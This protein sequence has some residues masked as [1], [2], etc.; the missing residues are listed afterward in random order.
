[1]TGIA[2]NTKDS[3]TR[4]SEVRRED[5]EALVN[6]V[7][8]V[9]NRNAEL[10]KRVEEL[11]YDY[12]IKEREK[13]GR[14][15]F[16]Y[17]AFRALKFNHIDGDY[18]EF[19]SHG[20]TTFS[21]AYQES[22]RQSRKTR[23]WAFD[24]FQG[25]PA[26]TETRDEHPGWVEKK[27]TTSLDRF[28]ELCKERGV[29]RDAYTVVPGYYNQT[30]PAMSATDEPNNIA[31]AYIDCD[32]YS[33][34]RDVLDFLK[35]RV[36]HGMILAFDDYFCWSSTQLSG[37]RSAML[38]AFPKTGEWELVPYMQFGWHGQSFVVERKTLIPGN[39]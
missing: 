20:G 12:Q 34:T 3:T 1:M 14:L 24:S 38:E 26:Q 36:K 21:L 31:M 23:L 17:N 10:E 16:F 4:E 29:P 22:A 18:V 33:S 15:E 13:L 11:H 5:F 25:L 32:L 7:E 35:P 8:D 27:M 37:E 30:L 39:D 28:H 9:K 19:G 6:L 2:D